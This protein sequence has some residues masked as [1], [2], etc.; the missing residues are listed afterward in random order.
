M[1]SKF[2]IIAITILTTNIV[3]SENPKPTRIQ[4]AAGGFTLTTIAVKEQFYIKATA[5]VVNNAN[6]NIPV[7]P[8]A[9][10]S[11]DGHWKATEYTWAAN[12]KETQE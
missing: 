11:L 8:P 7:P 9:S 12:W 3:F 6:A 2:S 10:T 1:K 4:T 5:L